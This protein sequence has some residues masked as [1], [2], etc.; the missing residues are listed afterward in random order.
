MFRGV[1]LTLVLGLLVLGSNARDLQQKTP[2][3]CTPLVDAAQGAGL[4]TLIAALQA[5]GLVENVTAPDAELTVFAPTNDGFDRAL[6]QLGLTLDDLVASPEVLTEI[7]L[8]HVLPGFFRAADFG[9]GGT[10]TTALGNMS[11]CG[12]G[13]VDVV[14]GDIVTVTGGETNATV[15]TADVETCT[16]IVHVIDFVLLPCPLEVDEVVDGEVPVPEIVAVATDANLTTLLDLVTAAGLVDAVAAGN[17]T[18]FAPTNEAFSTALE[19]L[20]ITAEDLIA[21]QTV[22]TEILTYHVLPSPFTAAD[23]GTGGTFETLLGDDSSCGVGSVDVQVEPDGVV[24]IVGGVTS[25]SV[26]TFDVQ[27]GTTI[28]HVIDGVLLPCEL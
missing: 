11:T 16:A 25:A 4:T 3:A 17:L 26:I 23:F 27:A 18:I 8:Y 5:A 6:E 22:L 24:R 20:N 7:L 21:N 28:I 10:F 15:V 14:V 13:D 12:V 1:V 19:A 2:A 9:E